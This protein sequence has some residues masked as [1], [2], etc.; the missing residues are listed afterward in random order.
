MHLYICI[1]LFTMSNFL[2][3]VYQWRENTARFIFVWHV[4]LCEEEVEITNRKDKLDSINTIQERREIKILRRVKL[5]I[6]F[7]Y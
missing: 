1:V 5:G 4:N 2:S 6:A 7:D 3:K